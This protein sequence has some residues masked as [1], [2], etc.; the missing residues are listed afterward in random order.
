MAT[1]PVHL[2]G[3]NVVTGITV[4]TRV[5]N[6]SDVAAGLQKLHDLFGIVALALHVQHACVQDGQHQPRVEGPVTASI[7]F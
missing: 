7:K 4:Q 1:N 2:F 3:G 5:V 6:A